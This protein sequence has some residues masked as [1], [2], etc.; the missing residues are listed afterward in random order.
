VSKITALIRYKNSVES[1][2]RVL[3]ALKSQ[4]LAV[5]RI[6][7][8]DSGSTDGS[9]ALLKNSNADV[10]TWAKTYHHST[11]LNYGIEHCETPLV[12]CLSSHTVIS[13]PDGVRKMSTQMEDTNVAATSIKWDN[14][15]FYSDQID[16]T[17]LKEKGMKLGSIYTN[18]LGLIRRQ[19]W[20]DHRFD[21]DLNGIEDY[22]WA[23]YQLRSGRLIKRLNLNID[24]IR[25][26]NSRE[27]RDTARIFSIA[28]RYQ[29]PITWLG[30]KEAC[31]RILKNLGGKFAGDPVAHKEFDICRRRLAGSLLWKFMDLNR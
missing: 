6:L 25:Q 28:N 15:P 29:L 22:E 19:H 13:D 3:A 9:T 23:I 30:R 11:V 5:D 12:L 21:E 24:Y 14:D 4:T 26:G 1:L 31:L 18:S 27:F 16:W 10:I 20:L 17:E 7:A 2:P 8:V